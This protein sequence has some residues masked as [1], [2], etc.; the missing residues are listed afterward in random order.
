M[1]LK[2]TALPDGARFQKSVKSY[3]A[4]IHMPVS[5]ANAKIYTVSQLTAEIKSILEQRF[6]FVWLGGEISNFRIPSSGHFYF[7]LKDDTAQIQAVMFRSESLFQRYAEAARYE[8]GE[9]L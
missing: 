1:Y 4:L 9:I 8:P 3:L 5:H 7:T 6:A 2:I